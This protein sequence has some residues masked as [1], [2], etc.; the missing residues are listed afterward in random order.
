[1]GKYSKQVNKIPTYIKKLRD[2]LEVTQ[3]AKNIG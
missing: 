2:I 1:M 3:Y